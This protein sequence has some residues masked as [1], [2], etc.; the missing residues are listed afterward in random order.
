M[1][2]K[3]E[4]KFKSPAEYRYI[5]K[6]TPTVDRDDICAGRGDFRH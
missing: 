6:D 4:L 1:P 2:K 5:G 3:D